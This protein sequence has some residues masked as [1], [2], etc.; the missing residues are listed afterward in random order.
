VLLLQ[1]FGC[2]RQS[3][4]LQ[5]GSQLLALHLFVSKFFAGIP[6]FYYFFE[7]HCVPSFCSLKIA[8]FYTGDHS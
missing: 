6:V 2:G 8:G 3:P 1:I 7:F 4:R 5:D